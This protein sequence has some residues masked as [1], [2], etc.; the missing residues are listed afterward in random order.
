VLPKFRE[1]TIKELMKLAH[2]KLNMVNDVI[3]R[4]KHFQI[5][6][7]KQQKKDDLMM[8]KMSKK[9]KIKDM[10]NQ[11]T[12]VAVKLSMENSLNLTNSMRK[13]GRYNSLSHVQTIQS[14]PIDLT[15]QTKQKEIS[16]L[17]STLE[18]LQFMF[19]P[20]SNYF[21]NSIESQHTEFK[22]VFQKEKYS[23]LESTKK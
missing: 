7:Y 12:H 11:P 19:S 14:L 15:M 16:N 6:Q 2:H 22:Q 5:Q 9:N 20:N 18:N 3:D 8:L 1:E 13:M 4:F 21:Y 10:D 23:L 17:N